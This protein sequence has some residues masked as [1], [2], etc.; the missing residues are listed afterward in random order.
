MKIKSRAE[1]AVT[2]EQAGLAFGYG[3]LYLGLAWGC[4]SLYPSSL[5]F[6]SFWLPAGLSVA[7][8]I[9]NDVRRWTLLAVCQLAANA[10]FNVLFY[11]SAPLALVFAF[12]NLAETLV[13]AY[14]A[15][16]F[17]RGAAAFD[18]LSTTLG[19]L[20]LAALAA[21]A[22]GGAISLAGAALLGRVDSPLR[23]WTAWLGSDGSGIM[24]AAV[25]LVLW[26]KPSD[27]PS[28]KPSLP[29]LIELLSILATLTAAV[30]VGFVSPASANPAARYLA[31]PILLWAGIRFPSRVVSLINVLFMALMNTSISLSI[32]PGHGFIRFEVPAIA[33]IFF[34]VAFIFDFLP[35]VALAGMRNAERSLRAS[36]SE[37]R[38][39]Q[40]QYQDLLE[41]SQDLIWQCDAEGRFIY[42]NT[43]WDRLLGFAHS[44]MIGRK[45]YD[46]LEPSFVAD[47]RA[48]ASVLREKGAIMGK[49]LRLRKKDGGSVLLMCNLKAARGEYGE[50]EGAR[51]T[52][53][54]IT[55]RRRLEEAMYNAQKQ[56]SLGVLAGGLAHDFNNLLGGVFG[57][58]EF[59]LKATDIEKAHGYLKRTLV[60]FERAKDLTRQLLTFSKGGTPAK[61]SGSIVEAL[62][63]SVAFALSGRNVQAEFGSVQELPRF[64]FDPNQMGQVFQNIAINAC[65]AMPEGGRISVSVDSAAVGPEA[66]PLDPGD[67]VRI[68]IGDQGPGIPPDLIPRVFDPFF[69]T[70][71][72]GSGLGLAICYSIVSKH[73]GTITVESP[74]GGGALFT[75]LLPMGQGGEAEA[76]P[77]DEGDGAAAEPFLGSGR[78]LVMDDEAYMREL[79]AELLSGL[80]FEVTAAEDGDIA[81]SV[82]SRAMEEGRRIRLAMLDLT[83]PGGRGGLETVAELRRAY[84]DSICVIAASGYA[85]DPVIANPKAYGFD[86]AIAKPYLMSELVRLLG[87]L[88]PRLPDAR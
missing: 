71:K 2:V 70:K 87:R 73:K 78:A 50:F 53:Y 1:R 20:G 77:G 38:R 40:G 14:L 21:P 60:P 17:A 49:E 66:A 43:A 27:S 47:L 76:S 13:G 61:Q 79:G 15:R 88:L 29:A 84:G 36:A 34:L 6:A 52:A 83:V 51:G 16:R 19:F 30:Y 86:G 33:Q 8:F 54:D 63:E 32:H 67:Y 80:G 45:Y 35:C 11:R 42:L 72:K 3:L 41:T 37:A 28:R 10:A 24:V 68:R 18:K 44:E 81:L 85:E 25:P 75:I 82:F 64:A 9:L 23:F 26:L 65:E 62:R 22:L 56:E 58:I 5:G 7:I 69:T 57:F 39:L 48:E 46:F 74:R 12:A 59:A 4:S 55:E 31:M